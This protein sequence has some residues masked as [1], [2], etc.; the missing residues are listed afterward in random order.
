M[1]NSI[2]CTICGIVLT[3]TLTVE[4]ITFNG[5]HVPEHVPEQRGGFSYDFPTD[6]Q[7]VSVS[8]AINTA[9]TLTAD[10]TYFIQR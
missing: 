2:K 8:G 7:A 6:F 4:C 1:N 9:S 5:H 3:A 10:L